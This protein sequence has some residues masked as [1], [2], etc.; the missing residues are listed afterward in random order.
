[1]AAFVGLAAG[2]IGFG[3]FAGFFAGGV[4]VDGATRAATRW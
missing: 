3:F 2:L 4:G 1:L